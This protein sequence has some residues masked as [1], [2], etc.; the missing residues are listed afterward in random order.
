MEIENILK[1]IKKNMSPKRYNHSINVAKKCK[2]LASVYGE[3]EKDSEI[4]GLLHDCAKEIS[5]NKMLQYIDKSDII[6]EQDFYNMPYI[7]HSFAGANVAKEQFLI[8]DQNILNAIKYHTVA[9]PFMSNLEKIVYISDLIS[10]D[11][12]YNEVDNIRENIKKLNI[13]EAF[14]YTLKE[15]VLFLIK[16][17]KPIYKQTIDSYNFYVK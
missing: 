4:C 6:Y 2:E 3:N 11:R 16:S 17:N 5:S 15:S 1:Y 14:I 7:W 8:T 10:C 13:N 9:R 12:E